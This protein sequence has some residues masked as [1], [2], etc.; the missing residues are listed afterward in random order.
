[1]VNLLQLYLF[2]ITQVRKVFFRE[3]RPKNPLNILTSRVLRF[4]TKKEIAIAV[5]AVTL[6][7]HSRQRK[8]R[9]E[10]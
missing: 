4:I 1:L 10:V 5:S 6:F 8:I 7:C 9:K 3:K 2:L